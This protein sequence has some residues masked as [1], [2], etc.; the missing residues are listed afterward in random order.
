MW[1]SMPQRI[2]FA[3]GFIAGMISQ[4]PAVIGSAVTAAGNFLAQLPGLCVQYGMAFIMAA[5]AWLA[6]AY[7]TVSSGIMNT[8]MAAAEWLM[9]LPSVCYDAGAAFIAAAAAWL[10]S[11]YDTAVCR[12]GF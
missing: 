4:L 5:A 8:I 3:I 10:A 6:S 2:L 11:A 1:L 7:D 12:I 9:Q